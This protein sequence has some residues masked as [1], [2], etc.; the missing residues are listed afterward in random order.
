[1]LQMLLAERAAT[2]ASFV[3]LRKV[4]YGG[5]P[6][7]QT[8][9][10]QSLEMIGCQ[11]LQIYASTE[12]GNV[13]VC[14]PPA[15][16]Y[17]G[18]QLLGAAGKAYPGVDVKIIDGSGRS[19]PSGEVGEI[20]V[21]TPARMLEYWQLPDATARTLVDGWIHTG[22]AGYLDDAGYLFVGDRI[23]DMIIVAGQNVYPAEVENA[24][25]RHPAVAEVAVIGIPDERW[26]EAI[27]ACVALRPAGDT[28]RAHG[29]GTRAPGRLQGADQLR[30][31]RRPAPQPRRQDPPPYPARPLLA[32]PRPQG[33]LAGRVRRS[34]ILS[35]VVGWPGRVQAAGPPRWAR[36]SMRQGRD[37]SWRV[38]AGRRGDEPASA[39]A[40]QHDRQPARSPLAAWPVV[41]PGQPRPASGAAA[42]VGQPVGPDGVPVPHDHGGRAARAAGGAAVRIVHVAGVD[43]LQ[44]VAQRDPPGPGQRG[45]RSRRDVAHLVVRME[46]GEMQRH[47]HAEML[48]DPPGLRVDLGIAVVPARDEQRGDLHPDVRLL[49]EVHQGVKHR[50]EVA[51]ADPVVEVLGERLE[52]DVGGVHVRVQLTPGGR[53][54]VPGGDRDRLDTAPVAGVGHVRGIFQEDRRIV[55]GERHAAGAER[56]GGR[57]EL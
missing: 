25:A 26:G 12:T 43:V 39:A 33:E 3:S 46:R 5:S 57:G 55:V 49:P 53:L 56:L 20:C 2:P 32:P 31:R 22:D 10:R 11:F 40:S 48:G 44:A 42:V 47:V 45:R 14:L 9:L 38:P 17:P 18:S 54:D 37:P 28:T 24:L 23:K 36:V 30:L 52:V 19:L 51:R 27:H 15:D 13:A 6:I 35:R 8:L 34:R 29:V 21:R 16:H 50:T 41:D 7:S 1:M 4:V